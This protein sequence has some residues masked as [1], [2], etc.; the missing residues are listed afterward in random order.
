MFQFLKI[1]Q[2]KMQFQVKFAII[3]TGALIIENY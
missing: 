3:F 2:K 1:C